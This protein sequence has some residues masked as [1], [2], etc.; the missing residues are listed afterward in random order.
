MGA[1]LQGAQDLT[2]AYGASPCSKL[3]KGLGPRTLPFWRL[4][5]LA[6]ALRSA[7]SLP[8]VVDV[9]RRLCG[10]PRGCGQLCCPSAPAS[11]SRCSRRKGTPR[12]VPSGVRGSRCTANHTRPSPIHDAV[13]VAPVENPV[14]KQESRSAQRATGSADLG[15]LFYVWRPFALVALAVERLVVPGESTAI[16]GSKVVSAVRRCL[17]ACGRGA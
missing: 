11:K 9:G 12:T 8:V 6:L 13:P 1:P 3:R 16:R 5:R 4:V 2:P 17:L 10:C 7:V 15:S 14:P